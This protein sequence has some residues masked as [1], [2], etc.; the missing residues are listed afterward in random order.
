M[1]FEN[2]TFLHPIYF[3]WVLPILVWLVFIYL[4]KDTKHS[5]SGFSDLEQAYGQNS[6]FYTLYFLL[7]FCI[8]VLFLS[9][10]AH[11]VQYNSEKKIH[12]NGI[13]IQLVMDLSYSMIAKDLS[14]S[15]LEVA[16]KM[17]IGFIDGRETDRIWLMLFSGKPFT[18]VPLS[19]DYAF[20][21]SYISDVSIETIDRRYSRL[22]W[23]AIWDALVLSHDALKDDVE[24]ERVIILITDGEANAWINPIAAL[25]LLK[26][27]QI[28]AYTIWVWWTDETFIE[29]VDDFGLKRKLAVWPVDEDTLEKIASETGWKYYRA[30]SQEALEE[31]F[32]SI[33]TLETKEIEQTVVQLQTDAYEPFLYLLILLFFVFS[34]LIYRKNIIIS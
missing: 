26:D 22:W 19:F 11:P 29:L 3:L 9:I 8:S 24:R 34:G 31:I 15:R 13:D 18:S 5:F 10:L 1:I 32:E 23:T 16:K 17:M 25:K 4:K 27:S 21:R 6:I 30:T 14:P 20:L 2:L 33:S 28:R 12:K 7:I